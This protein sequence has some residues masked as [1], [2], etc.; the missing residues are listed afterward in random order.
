MGLVWSLYFPLWLLP[1]VSEILIRE[2]FV[3][4]MR[5]GLASHGRNNTFRIRVTDAPMGKGRAFLFL[6]MPPSCLYLKGFFGCV[7]AMFQ[8][9]TIVN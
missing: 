2:Q 8:R 6:P 5:G 7:L 9:S 1:L 3:K 4:S